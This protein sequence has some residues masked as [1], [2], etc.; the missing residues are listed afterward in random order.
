MSSVALYYL[1]ATVLLMAAFVQRLSVARLARPSVRWVEE[2]VEVEV[3]EDPSR[4]LFVLLSFEV[5]W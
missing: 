4:L 1:L 3:L 5:L 2:F